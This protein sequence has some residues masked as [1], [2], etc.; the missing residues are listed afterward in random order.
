MFTQCSLQEMNRSGDC[1]KAKLTSQTSLTSQQPSQQTGQSG[2]ETSQ[3]DS[4]GGEEP[5]PQPG[6]AEKELSKE[7]KVSKAGRKKGMD[8]Q[9]TYRPGFMWGQLCS[10]FKQ[11]RQYEDPTNKHYKKIYKKTSK[12]PKVLKKLNP[13]TL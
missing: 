2:Q 6:P 4:Q 7:A 12:K 9:K 13:K 3:Q 1:M 8:M 5:S 10:W 11:V